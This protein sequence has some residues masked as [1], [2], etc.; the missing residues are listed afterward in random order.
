MHIHLPATIIKIVSTTQPYQDCSS[1]AHHNC[2][3][4]VSVGSV[5]CLHKVQVIEGEEETAVAVYWV[6]YVIDRCHVGFLCCH[7]NKDAY[8]YNWYMMKDNHKR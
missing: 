6:S 2:G 4:V 1:Q 5:V 8:G 7:L 3:A